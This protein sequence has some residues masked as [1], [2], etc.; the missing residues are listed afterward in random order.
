MINNNTYVVFD[1][2]TGGLDPNFN[3]AIQVAGKAYDPRSLE[4]IPVE[5]GG[6]F[7]SYMKPEF[8]DRL[9]PGAMKVNK[10]SVETLKAAPDVG[11]VWPKFVEWVQGFN[12]KKGSMWTAPIPCGKNIV[13]FDFKF[14]EVLNN[15][16]LPK[17]NETVI[18]NRIV[19]D[20]DFVLHG[21]FEN[22]LEPA[23]T[24]MDY[25]RGFFGIPS[26]GAHDALIDC[27]QTGDLLMRF[28]K[29][30]RYMQ[31]MENKNGERLL[32]WRR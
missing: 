10:I 21:W 27:R 17:K 16:W 29:M 32:K 5:A 2:E 6:E 13:N 31:K 18:W 23:K 9:T 3:E 20:L 12:P 7:M 24:N 1:F 11:V 30:Q 8:F 22:E 25:L 26:E 14:M 19:Q 4:P 15:K 28:F